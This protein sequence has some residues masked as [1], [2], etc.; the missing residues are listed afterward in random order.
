MDRVDC[1]FG[2]SLELEIIF[3]VRDLQSNDF[4]QAERTSP[5]S[6]QKKIKMKNP[7]NVL[8]TANMIWNAWSAFMNV[9]APNTQVRPNRLHIPEMFDISLTVPK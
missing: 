4:A 8:A 3:V 7:C 5:L 6:T 9:S 1:G 2:D